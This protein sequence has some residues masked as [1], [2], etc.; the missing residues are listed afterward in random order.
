MGRVELMEIKIDTKEL[1]NLIKQFDE[2]AKLVPKELFE[3]IAKNIAGRY[4]S[5]VIPRTPV[6]ENESFWIKTIG[7][8][9]SPV[10]VRGG[11]LR[12][13]WTEGKETAEYINSMPVIKNGSIHQFTISNN[14]S[15]APYVE[16]GHLQDVGRFVPYIGKTINGVRQGARLKRP[17]VKGTFMMT[18]TNNEINQM[19]PGLGQKLIMEYLEKTFGIK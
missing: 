12:K 3:Y 7:G 8:G 10:M 5:R 2:N 4:L 14:T 1:D 13:G 6:Q 15:Y 11:K 17:S 19:L 18:T 16:Y 9:R